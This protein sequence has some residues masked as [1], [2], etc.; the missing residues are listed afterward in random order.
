M[1]LN[2]WLLSEVRRGAFQPLPPA[3]STAGVQAVVADKAPVPET[4]G[5]PAPTKFC[6]A[7]SESEDEE[8][9]R[10]SQIK[11]RRKRSASECLQL[12]SDGRPQDLLDEELIALV[13]QK[14]IPLYALEKSLQDLERAVKIRRAAV[15]TSPPLPPSGLPDL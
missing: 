14:K 5:R 1:G 6:F 13:Q 2:A 9:M 11:K 7:E 12:L 8:Q 4:N 10:I 15:C 3:K